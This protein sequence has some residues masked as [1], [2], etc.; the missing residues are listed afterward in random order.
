M[1]V[2]IKQVKEA[3]SY[4]VDQV[5]KLKNGNIMVRKG[6]FYRNGMDADNFKNLVVAALLKNGIVANVI[7]YGD[8]WAAFTGGASVARQSHFYVE[9]A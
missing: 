3:L 9:L 7:D 2:T 4:S 8:H 1:A 6:Y 5:S